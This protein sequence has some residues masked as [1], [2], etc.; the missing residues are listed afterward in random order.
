VASAVERSRR[1]E[2][3]DIRRS[4]WHR[5]EQVQQVGYR[6]HGLSVAER[7]PVGTAA[8]PIDSLLSGSVPEG[9]IVFR[10]GAAWRGVARQ[11]SA[12]KGEAR[13]GGA[14]CGKVI[15]KNTLAEGWG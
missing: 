6:D 8:C 3:F 14:R 9:S 7:R 1:I 5:H 11:G 4:G 2:R 10:L 15:Y 12:R 13:L